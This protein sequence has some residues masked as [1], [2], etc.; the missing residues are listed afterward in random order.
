MRWARH[1]TAQAVSNPAH[2][3]E[4]LGFR[5]AGHDV[6][7]G[8]VHIEASLSCILPHVECMSLAAQQVKDLLVVDLDVRQPDQHLAA[9]RSAQPLEHLR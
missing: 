9:C 5:Q 1:S 4:A 6:H 3:Q 8:A 2:L 7:A